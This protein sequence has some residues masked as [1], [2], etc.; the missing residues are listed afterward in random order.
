MNSQSALEKYID[1]ELQ[2]EKTF[3]DAVEPILQPIGWTASPQMTL[4]LFFS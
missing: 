2:F 3:L 1:K 4:D